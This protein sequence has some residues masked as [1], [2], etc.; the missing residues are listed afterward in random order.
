MLNK[1]VTFRMSNKEYKTLLDFFM[2]S[3]L[4]NRFNQYK[5]I[6]ECIR[7]ILLNFILLKS[8]KNRVNYFNTNIF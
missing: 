7:Y 8:N 3:N 5:T 6:S 4:N 1:V 2:N